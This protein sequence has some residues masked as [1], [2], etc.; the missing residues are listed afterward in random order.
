MTIELQNISKLYG[1]QKALDDVSLSIRKG[2]ITGL[3]GPNGA[4]K[5]TMMKIICCFLPPTEGRATVHAYDVME[6]PM[7]VKSLIGYLP[8]NNPLY[9]DMYVKEYL[10]YIAGVFKIKKDI[11]TRI[12]D[13]I[14]LTGLQPEQN[15]KIGALS[16]GYKQRVGLA[17]ALIHNPDVLILDE[18]TSG[19]DPNQLVEIRALIKSI[20]KDKTVLLSTHI[21]QE[22]EAICDRVLIINNGKLVADEATSEMSKLFQS[23]EIITVEFDNEVKLDVLSKLKKIEYV[24]LVRSKVYEITGIEGADI[25]K[26]IFEWAVKNEVQILEMNTKEISLEHVFRKLTQ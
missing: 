25:R 1:K 12:K 4:G 17:Q 23:A 7:K 22:V 15:K 10:R 24:R 16:K 21:M 14:E 8:E 19:L 3:L 13:V 26:I 9:T 18:P 11:A 5:S 6:A 20:G 2:E